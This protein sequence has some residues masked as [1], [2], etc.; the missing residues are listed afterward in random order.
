MN[1]ECNLCCEPYKKVTR[2]E[3]LCYK[4]GFH[5]CVKCYKTYL[6]STTLEAHCM[7]KSCGIIWNRDF[8]NSTFDRSF[9]DKEYKK[10]M[11]NILFESE[12]A[13][14][15]E[16]QEKVSILI[17]EEKLNKK[18][19][20]VNKILSKLK[21]ELLELKNRRLNRGDGDEEE[22]EEKRKFIKKCS[23]KD[24]RGYLSKKHVCDICSNTFC[25]KCDEIKDEDDDEKHECDPNNV[26][27]VELLK[28]D[29]KPCPGCGVFIFKISGCNQCF[30]TSC[31]TPFDWVTGKKIVSGIFHNPHHMEWLISQGKDP[32]RNIGDIPCGGLENPYDF[33]VKYI[34]KIGKNQLDILVEHLRKMNEII[35]YKMR[36]LAHPNNP[37]NNE[38]LR[39][40]Y[41]MSEIDEK[42][43]KLT[44]VSR[45]KRRQKELEERNIYETLIS[46]TVDLFRDF[47]PS[48]TKK[49]IDDIQNLCDYV[50]SCFKNVADKYG[51]KKHEIFTFTVE[52][53]NVL[54]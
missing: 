36:K 21:L 14:L 25:S 40:K 49:T 4:C 23:Y 5:C 26:A 24:C 1:T 53:Y 18:I 3:V 54:F 8:L 6:F 44:I 11:E 48:K 7:D 15:P 41:L 27:T 9:I 37:R 2:K 45:E 42:R 34:K 29:S 46:V 32:V 51:L 22:K 43:F 50:N 20:K 31:K 35:D 28:K 17:E 12:K 19:S 10:H 39:I 13:L 47:I 30:C 16:S 52:V 33:W 38:D